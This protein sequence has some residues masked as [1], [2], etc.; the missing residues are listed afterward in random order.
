[1]LFDGIRRIRLNLNSSNAEA[2]ECLWETSMFIIY[3]F[4]E[5]WM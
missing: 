4:P 1:M 5:I 2:E 3:K